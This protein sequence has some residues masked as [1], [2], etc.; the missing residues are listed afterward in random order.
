MRGAQFTATSRF[1][2][3]VVKLAV[4][5]TIKATDISASWIERAFAAIVD[6]IGVWSRPLP[7]Y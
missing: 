1:T 2:Q 4:A 3:T 5:S 6:R 7:R